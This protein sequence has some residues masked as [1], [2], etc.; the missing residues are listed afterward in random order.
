LDFPGHDRGDLIAGSS[1]RDQHGGDSD[2]QLDLSPD[3][4]KKENQQP[5]TDSLL[6]SDEGQ[7]PQSQT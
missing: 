1:P 3:E 4:L 6:P 7:K 2:H 5:S